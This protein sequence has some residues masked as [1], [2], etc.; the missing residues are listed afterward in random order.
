MEVGRGRGTA[1]LPQ[2]KSLTDSAE[3][4]VWLCQLG[5]LDGKRLN[6]ALPSAKR[7]S[8]PAGALTS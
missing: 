1:N 3:R 8:E 5:Y 6:R 2:G 4:E 7:E